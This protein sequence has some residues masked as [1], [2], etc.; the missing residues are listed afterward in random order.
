MSE[1]KKEQVKIYITMGLA[2]ILVVLSYF[3]F[4]YK[5]GALDEKTNSY[6]LPVAALD[7]P[8]VKTKITKTNYWR[9]QTQDKSLSTL[10][11]DIFV[12]IKSMNNVGSGFLEDSLKTNES[13]FAVI[14]TPLL[15]PEMELTGTIVGGGNPIAIIN[16]QF[17]RV[18]DLVDEYKLVSIGKREVVLNM[19]GREVKVGMLK[20]E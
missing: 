3:R 4:I 11:R 1:R 20:N 12:N 15:N 14:N 5:K 6:N 17:V 13:S 2:L 18:G 16:D 8:A 10:K 19:D 9:Q 7:V